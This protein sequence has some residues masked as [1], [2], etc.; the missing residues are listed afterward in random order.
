MS[1]VIE[2][3]KKNR[4]D[5]AGHL[6]MLD[7]TKARK[8]QCFNFWVGVKTRVAPVPETASMDAIHDAVE[9]GILIDITEHP[10]LFIPEKQVADVEES[11]TGK[12]IYSGTRQFFTDLGI[13]DPA[14]D[15]GCLPDEVVAYATGDKSEQ[16]KIEAALAAAPVIQAEPV[17]LVEA[18]QRAQRAKVLLAP[19]MDNP[20]KYLLHVVR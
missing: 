13:V 6:L 19:G 16:A 1:T 10:E 18:R 14:G 8:W 20:E 7:L 11:D 5:Y 3:P 4:P 9:A 12:K 15:E 17:S 2:F